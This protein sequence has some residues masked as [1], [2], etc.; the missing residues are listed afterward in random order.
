MN[1]D[2]ID[3]I[4]LIRTA[5]KMGPPSQPRH[6]IINKQGFLSKEAGHTISWRALQIEA[7]GLPKA[8]GWLMR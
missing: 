5:P 8:D 7:Y 1:C 6:F 4:E 2:D 3:D